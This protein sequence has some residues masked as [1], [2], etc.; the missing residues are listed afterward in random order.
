M[1][2]VLNVIGGMHLMFIQREKRY[3]GFVVFE[4]L[5]EG[6]PISYVKFLKLIVD[7]SAAVV[8]FGIHFIVFL[9]S[10]MR[11]SLLFIRVDVY[12]APVPLTVIALVRYSSFS[13]SGTRYLSSSSSYQSTPNS[14][15]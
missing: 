6:Q 11:G 13:Y 5:N 2:V 4:K 7:G 15:K 1:A 8:N 9:H 14:W 12:V 10:T 3:E